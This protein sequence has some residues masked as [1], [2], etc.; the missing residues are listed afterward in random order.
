M[1]DGGS[2]ISDKKQILRTH[3]LKTF[4]WVVGF[5]HLFKNINSTKSS[6]PFRNGYSTAS[7][8]QAQMWTIL[9]YKFSH[10]LYT[11]TSFLL[12]AF[13]SAPTAFPSTFTCQQTILQTPFNCSW[14]HLSN[15]SSEPLFLLLEVPLVLMLFILFFLYSHTIPLD[16]AS[17]FS[18][19]TDH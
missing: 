1:K 15:Q 12:L 7:D 16:A 9:Y 13:P 3:V 14:E 5:I 8:A 2:G 11:F 10:H 19:K 4:S 6:I 17:E 18:R